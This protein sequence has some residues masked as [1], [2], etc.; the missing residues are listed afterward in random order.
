MNKSRNNCKMIICGRGKIQKDFEYIFSDIKVDYYIIDGNFESIEDNIRSYDELQKEDKTNTVV[1][2]CKD[3]CEADIDKLVQLGWEYKKNI[4][5]VKDYITKLDYPLF[6]RIEN[7][8]VIVWGT[9][10]VSKKFVTNFESVYTGINIKFFVDNNPLKEGESFCGKKIISPLKIESF[11]KYFIII[12]IA[13]INY[14]EVC[15]QLKSYNISEDY[16]IYCEYLINTPSKMLEITL[17][18]EDVFDEKC[19]RMDNGIRIYSTG[20]VIPCCIAHKAI[21]GNILLENFNDIWNSIYAK[22]CRLSLLNRTYSYC[23]VKNCLYLKCKSKR[24]YNEED[25]QNVYNYGFLE[26]PKS[27]ETDIDRSCN[28]HC[29]SCRKEIIIE[30]NDDYYKRYIESII[31]IVDIPSRLILNAR[32]DIFVSDYCKEII[33]SSNRIKK[34]T[35]SIL[36]NGLLFNKKNFKELFEQYESIEVSVSI[37]A[38]TAKTYSEL[39]GGGN[40]KI[41]CENLKYMSELRKTNRITWFQ[42]NMCVQKQNIKE[43][44]AFIDFGKSLNVDDVHLSKIQ[45]WGTSSNEEF[46]DNSCFTD[47]K[48]KEEYKKYFTE[49]IVNDGIVSWTDIS[50]YLN[51]PVKYTY[52]T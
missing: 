34:G 37:D 16:F 51:V 39:R 14:K 50:N 9:G 52:M 1:I 32:G 11:D 43:M 28:L 19:G 4:Y 46:D 22:I 45:N 33:K 35:I 40:F 21:Y 17:F 5:S 29:K 7:K 12:A 48:I 3:S 23:S 24:K 42:I 8:E 10:D 25:Y 20:D 38:A 6:D 27:I 30:K 13:K 44:K 31:K 15:D 36:T 18:C 47:W 49:D 26:V 41:L 2:V